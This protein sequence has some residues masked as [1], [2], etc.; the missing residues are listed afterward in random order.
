[1]RIKSIKIHNYRILHNVEVNLEDDITL[2]VGKNNSGKTSFFEIIR[3]ILSDEGFLSFEDFS[4]N[5]YNNFKSAEVLYKAYLAKIND[6]DKEKALK[7]LQEAVPK[8]ELYL[9]FEYDKEYDSL[10]ELSEFITDLDPVRNDACVYICYEPYNSLGLFKAF[11]EQKGN[12][13][14]LLIFLKDN[15]GSYFKTN[16][17]AFDGATGFKREVE[18]N[19][20]NK[21]Q[22]LV[23]FEEIKALRVLD[24][25]KGDRN[26]T[27]ALGF[28]NYY[29]QRDKTKEDVERLEATLKNVGV[30]LKGK[31][32]Q[33]LKNILE[34]LKT[35]G[36]ETPIVIPDIV[37]DSVFDS[38]SIIKNNIRY[39]YK[40]EEVNLP[41]SY[42]GLG[43]SNLIYMILEFASFIEKQVNA[44]QEKI[45]EFLVVMIEEPE[46]HMHPQMQQ[47]FISQIKELLRKAK[48]KGVITQLIITSHSSHIISEAGIDLDK[49][50]NR[51]RYFVKGPSYVITKDF[52]NLNIGDDEKTFRFLKQYLNLHKSDLFFA[53]KVIMVEGVTERLL[54]PQI[55]TKV[56]PSLQNEY[57]TVLEVGGAYTYKFKE[58]LEFI[59]VKTLLITDLDSINATT[60][61]ACQIDIKDA[62]I[63]TSN[64]TLLQWLPKK[65]I[66]TEL[67]RC[68]EADKV[69][70]DFVRVAFQICELDATYYPRSFEEAF[71]ERNK[72]LIN[73]EK[74]E[75]RTEKIRVA[76][77]EFSLFR[78]KSKEQ[79][80]KESSYSLAPTTSKAKTN[81]A[82]D[83][84][85]FDEKF[86][87]EWHVP[88]YIK[89]GLEWLAGMCIVK[90]QTVSE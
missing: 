72:G 87:G 67:L 33:I 31:Y 34:D 22:K 9:Y 50:F 43:Y 8:I 12:G 71:I 3:M 37:I 81:F 62:T 41:E 15:I 46:A 36:A 17:Y 48:A 63:K 68:K 2:I 66:I 83:V 85:S 70:N 14:S 10:I 89:E 4:Q 53:D 73:S 7:E 1:M 47:V 21:V 19:F 54:M 5:S 61:E 25:K 23:S 42:N 39:L 24:D 90:Y 65:A 26:N 13:L 28:A 6:E 56:A 45:S 60:R 27:L 78:T 58:I 76:K 18:G 38:E 86:Y 32:E 30:E 88:Y 64:E 35:F 11:T 55:I 59:S 16:C 20:K 49:G 44:K 69:Y 57:I 77:N 51:I 74:K 84:M 40:Q 29:R 82:F 79:I 52:N 80:V 75:S